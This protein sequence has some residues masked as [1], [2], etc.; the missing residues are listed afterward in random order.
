MKQVTQ[1]QRSSDVSVDEVPPPALRPGG[2]LVRTAFSLI[3]AG[4]E[5]AKLDVAGKSLVG[6]AR[7]K[8]EQVKQVI[9]AVRQQGLLTTVTKVQNRLSALSP[10]GYSASG[11]VLEVGADVEE[12]SVG[13]HVACAGAGYANH[14]E[15]NY[16][17]RNLCV[18]VPECR[19]KAPCQGTGLLPLDEAAF[20]TL[21]A[22]AM[23]GV[24]QA[25][26]RL[27]EVVVVIGLGLLGLL[28]TQLLN[29]A[30]CVVLGTDPDGGR[31]SMAVSLGAQVATPNVAEMTA[32][33][34][35]RSSGQGADAVIV[36][37]A[38]SSSEPLLIA[39]EMA[40]SKGR[41]VLVG[42]VGMEI[43]RAPYYE[44]ELDF[45]LSRSYGPGRYDP[46]YE[47]KGID[48]PYPFVRW[49][50]RRNMESFLALV[51]AGHVD[52][53]AL[54][55]H[56]FNFERAPD[57]YRLITEGGEPSLAVLLCYPAENKAKVDVLSRSD[58]PRESSPDGRDT[59][60]PRTFFQTDQR[61]WLNGAS[62]AI[63]AKS[64]N[65]RIRIGLIGAGNFAQG[66]ILP[67]LRR[68]SRAELRGVVS[69]TGLSARSVAGRFGFSYA[70]AST[71]DIIS[72]PDIDAVIV[73]TRHDS[74]ASIA[75]AAL[76]AGKSVF[77]EKPLA[78]DHHQLS[79][80]AAS[81]ESAR[82]PDGTAPVLMVGFNRRFA[83]TMLR[84]RE[85]CRSAGEALAIHYRVNA[86][87]LP[88]THWLHDPIVGG[89]RIIGEG[90]HFVDLVTCLAG[91]PVVEVFAQLLPN[92]N[93]YHQDNLVAQI[94][95]RNGSV[96]VLEYLANGSTR[97]AKERIEVL[98]GGMTAILDD[99]RTLTIANRSALKGPRRFFASQDKGHKA[100]VA[101]FLRA[102]REAGPPPIALTDLV[103]ST[104]ATFALVES[105]REHRSVDPTAVAEHRLHST[106]VEAMA[107]R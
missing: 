25:D 95:F 85:V 40:R 68:D 82:R 30:G 87:L 53:R 97:V 32:L 49:T 8:P 57:A 7:A 14:A 79:E 12:F 81:A 76:R 17:P 24:R 98:G 66:T 52:V 37:A 92:A 39:A 61:V 86:G 15:V 48:Y 67:V 2:V 64:S 91:A 71:E 72:D 89:G 62:R 29:A 73:A 26:V 34:K 58:G 31:C 106:P 63:S 59:A 84:L 56:R 103:A 46:Q 102:V 50:E 5:R 107:T 33:A 43:P 75:A 4:T 22:I 55:S 77:V 94:R 101:A 93:K 65:G 42:T 21:G 19:R 10:L 3:S 96:A 47:E 100:G 104:M 74:H 99:F 70:A 16:I 69:S 80:V 23:Q 38:T 54:I 41:V 88:A 35:Q 60:P 9:E 83:P 6:K 11:V 18:K 90:C 36:C 51:A 78:L 20:V 13:D 45:R 28:T 105:A 44:K 1:T 27:G